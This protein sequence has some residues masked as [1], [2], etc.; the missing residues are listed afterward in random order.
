[1]QTYKLN[2]LAN[3]GWIQRAAERRRGVEAVAG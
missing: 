1:M 3:P 2:R